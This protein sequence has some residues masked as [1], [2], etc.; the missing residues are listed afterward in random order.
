PKI[1]R[2]HIGEP[3][4]TAVKRVERFEPTQV[5]GLADRRKGAFG[6]SAKTVE[7]REE[8]FRILLLEMQQGIAEGINILPENFLFGKAFRG[9]RRG[10]GEIGEI[11]FEK[12]HTPVIPKLERLDELRKE[13]AI[14]K[15]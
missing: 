14:E 1:H 15:A 12:P 11:E 3:R 9:G 4:I 10:D 5:N 2:R 13:T 6:V 7:R 8:D